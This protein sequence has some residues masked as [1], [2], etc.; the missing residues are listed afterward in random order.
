[1]IKDHHQLVE[2]VQEYRN[3]IS[4]QDRRNFH[5]FRIDRCEFRP[6]YFRPRN[7]AHFRLYRST[8]RIQ[9]CQIQAG[10]NNNRT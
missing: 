4:P 7:I 6:C 3:C 2:Q 10:R 9:C 5:Q 1:M 8:R